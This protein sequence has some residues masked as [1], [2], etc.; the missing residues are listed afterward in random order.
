M[1]WLVLL[2]ALMEKDVSV[3]PETF[4]KHVDASLT[5][6]NR[7]LKQLRKLFLVEDLIDSLK[8]SLGVCPS[9]CLSVSRHSP[10]RV[11][12]PRFMIDSVKAVTPT[13]VALVCLCASSCILPHL[14]SCAYTPLC[15]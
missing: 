1:L 4:R 5:H 9:A 14:G 7:L 11:S 10:L 6:I 3:P 12:D 13:I 2:R 8:V 15:V